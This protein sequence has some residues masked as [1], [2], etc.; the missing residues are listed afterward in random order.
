M[1]EYLTLIAPAA[2]TL[3]SLSLCSDSSVAKRWCLKAISGIILEKAGHC[4]EQTWGHAWMN[5][6][7]I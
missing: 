5:G 2:G 1:I 3:L 7:R 4:D 6:Q